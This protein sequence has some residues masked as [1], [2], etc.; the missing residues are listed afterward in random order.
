VFEP[1]H[2][3]SVGD[4]DNQAGD[5]LMIAITDN[6]LSGFLVAHGIGHPDCYRCFW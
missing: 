3:A 2:S 4:G 1:G 5:T 6:S